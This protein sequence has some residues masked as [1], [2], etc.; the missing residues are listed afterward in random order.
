MGPSQNRKLAK[1]RKPPK[2]EQALTGANGPQFWKKRKKE[3]TPWHFWRCLGGEKGRGGGGK[4]DPER[5]NPTLGPLGK[6]K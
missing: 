6:K 1:E 4:K 3:G 2:V 5:E